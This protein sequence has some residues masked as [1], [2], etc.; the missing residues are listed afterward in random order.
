[1][2]LATFR[3]RVWSP[4]AKR[5]CWLLSEKKNSAALRFIFYQ[6]GKKD[7]S[8]DSN[9]VSLVRNTGSASPLRLTET[10]TVLLRMRFRR[11]KWSVDVNLVISSIMLFI[12]SI[13]QISSNIF[14]CPLNIHA[15]TLAR[16][17]RR[18]RCQREFPLSSAHENDRCKALL[19]T[20]FCCLA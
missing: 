9:P 4:P 13:S 15:T 8:T 11:P 7:A 19:C 16:H 3:R 10:K 14:S 5:V 18:F 1:M 17:F 2:R 20:D 6:I 12:T